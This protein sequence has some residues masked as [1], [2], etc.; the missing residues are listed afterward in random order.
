M[1]TA[2]FKNSSN[3]TS[4]AEIAFH[5]LSVD[6]D[7]LKTPHS[8]NE[9][10]PAHIYNVVSAYERDLP[11]TNPFL[12]AVA[13]V[14]TPACLKSPINFT[15]IATHDAVRRDLQAML[16]VLHQELGGTPEL[17]TKIDALKTASS[18]ELSYATHAV[19]TG[20]QR[21][22]IASAQKSVAAMYQQSRNG[23]WSR[24]KTSE[25][26]LTA[27]LHQAAQHLT[28]ALALFDAGDGASAFKLYNQVMRANAAPIHDFASAANTDFYL[29][30]GT[31]LGVMAAAGA[32]FAYTGGAA[33]YAFT[34]SATVTSTT[35]IGAY[36][37][38]LLVGGASCTLTEKL[39]SHAIFDVPYFQTHDPIENALEFTQSTLKTAAMVGYL[40][41]FGQVIP[42]PAYSGTGAKFINFG[43]G[44]T[45][46]FS[47][48]TTF[49]ALTDGPSHALSPDTM[50]HTLATVIG[51]RGGHAALR[52]TPAIVRKSIDTLSNYFPHDIGEVAPFPLFIAS[53]VAP[54]MSAFYLM[55]GKIPPAI[56]TTQFLGLRPT[57][58]RNI[59]FIQLLGRIGAS[60]PMSILRS[61]LTILGGIH[62]FEKDGMNRIENAADFINLVMANLGRATAGKQPVGF[63]IEFDPKTMSRDQTHTMMARALEDAGYTVK[64]EYGARDFTF[65]TQLKVAPIILGEAAIKGQKVRTEIF[66]ANGTTL[67]SVVHDADTAKTHML[68][69][70]QAKTLADADVLLHSILDARPKEKY[71]II[72]KDDSGDT[73][74]MGIEIT[75]KVTA[76]LTGL[77]GKF[78]DSEGQVQD[79]VD[80]NFGRHLSAANGSNRPQLEAIL[81]YVKQV[82][83]E[84]LAIQKTNRITHLQVDGLGNGVFQVV[85]EVPPY[86]EAISAKMNVGETG[87]TKPMIAAFQNS[88]FDGT[89][90]AKMVGMHVHAGVSYEVD[91]RVS[92]APALNLLRAFAA[93]QHYIYDL[94]PSHHNRSG[95]IQRMPDAY[96]KLLANPNYVTDPTDPVQIARVISDYNM[97]TPV[98]YSD[99]NM[100]NLFAVIVHQLGLNPSLAR[101]TPSKP[102]AELRLF[103]SIMDPDSVTF[104]AQF[105][106]SF[107]HKYANTLP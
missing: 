17:Q 80:I 21:N 76:R 14:K 98:K 5:N 61:A 88:G 71:L 92:I 56:L 12:L 73:L 48:L 27:H 83:P 46:E 7:Y 68:T 30:F 82:L 16:Q 101:A 9:T 33:L 22:V 107:V 102:T 43:A 28:E 84:T 15:Q 1:A 95:F 75:G 44:V 70:S 66:Q 23:L 106:G 99:L 41:G 79:T 11:Q 6:L 105:W 45:H 67:V 55:T 104:I 85:D 13:S 36:L 89:R 87:N 54:L 103:D 19:V 50:A 42:L 57:S 65:K 69:A 29:Q 18:D 20:L 51:L 77:N 38:S 60:R 31:G 78:Y 93:A 39:L 94:F 64:I 24:S 37:G 49:T 59:V 32:A 8:A 53:R 62:V 100:D 10:T 96:Q 40:R 86:L 91:G 35:G 72:A 74:K 4:K 90:A 26:L 81:A 34:G 58:P 97:H 3:G 25:H 47:G 63:E 52:R 2:H